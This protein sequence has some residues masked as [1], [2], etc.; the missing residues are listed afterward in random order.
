[1]TAAH[2]IT[3]ITGLFIDATTEYRPGQK[4]L[5]EFPKFRGTSPQ[6]LPE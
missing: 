5:G 6:K 4:F 3:A 2:V 1:V